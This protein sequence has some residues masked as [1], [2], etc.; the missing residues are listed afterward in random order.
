MHAPLTKIE[1][2][3]LAVAECRRLLADAHRALAEPCTV[4]EAKR[5]R[6]MVRALQICAREAKNTELIDLSGE[7]RRR[8]E[9]RTG[10]LL[11]VMDKAKGARGN[12]NGRGARI[13]QSPEDTAQQPSTLKEL[14]ITKTQSSRWQ[15][16]ANLAPSAFE[17][18]VT[19]AKNR[20]EKGTTAALRAAVRDK[21]YWLTPP[22]LMAE[23]QLE[24]DFDFDP[25]PYPRPKGFDGLKE[26]W[27]RSSYVNPIFGNGNGPT[28]WAHKAIKENK[29]GKTVVMV[30]PLDRWVLALLEAG[31][32]IRNLGNVKWRAVE[33]GTPGTGNG[34]YTAAFILKPPKTKS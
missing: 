23:L 13:V 33:D 11:K 16:L 26:E 8:W 21:H 15:K 22:D 17:T 12:P 30:W 9:R 7:I 1:A 18:Y 10:E 6:D 25:C 29:K 3:S 20:A 4:Q 19:D 24:F 5:T 31:A 32:K 2:A 34:R 28:A 27:G 14:G